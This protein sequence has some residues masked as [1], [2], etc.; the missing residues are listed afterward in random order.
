[1]LIKFWF[2][3]F[4]VWMCDSTFVR[5]SNSH[6]SKDHWPLGAFTIGLKVFTALKS[7]L[8]TH[9]PWDLNNSETSWNDKS[10]TGPWASE[11]HG[12]T[13]NLRGRDRCPKSSLSSF[14][15]VFVVWLSFVSQK[16]RWGFA[17]A[18]TALQIH[19]TAPPWGFFWP[20]C[21]RHEPSCLRKAVEDGT[22]LWNTGAENKGM[23]W[24]W[25][26]SASCCLL[27]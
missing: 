25:T 24:W 21:F 1:M 2:S 15:S 10:Q 17:L 5:H 13:G 23:G 27:H 16:P 14:F 4:Y 26:S 11:T 19:W 6:N 18:H 12:C 3:P 20:Y 22:Y 7:C 8:E 9:N